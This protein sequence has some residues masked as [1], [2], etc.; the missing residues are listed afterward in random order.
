MAE[1]S[2]PARE[3]VLHCGLEALHLLA[4][5]KRVIRSP[6]NTFADK[7]AVSGLFAPFVVFDS[8]KYLRRWA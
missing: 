7:D 3:A 4:N 8:V 5:K 6:G 2:R 1:T